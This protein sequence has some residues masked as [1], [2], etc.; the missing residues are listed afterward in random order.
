MIS[1]LLRRL[2][3]IGEYRDKQFDLVEKINSNIMKTDTKSENT[4]MKFAVD[5]Q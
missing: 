3:T 5:L 4:P 1:T 2:H